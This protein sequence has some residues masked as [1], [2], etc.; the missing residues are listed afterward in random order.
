[1]PRPKPASRLYTGSERWILNTLK[2]NNPARRMT[3]TPK[4]LKKIS[5][6][7]ILLLMRYQVGLN[8]HWHSPKKIR[9]V[10]LAKK[11]PDNKAKTR[12]LL[13]LALTIPLS[14]KIRTKIKIKKIYPILSTTLI[15]RMVIMPTSVPKKSHKTSA[16]LDNFYVSD[17]G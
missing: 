12:I 7:K 3:K 11:D 6:P 8:P 2:V 4:T 9:I 16:G 10:V 14:G 1:M 5:F 15:S 17:W 13:S